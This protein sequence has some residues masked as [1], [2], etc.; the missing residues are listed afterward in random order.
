LKEYTEKDLIKYLGEN[1]AARFSSIIE[2]GTNGEA[3]S[4]LEFDDFEYAG[5]CDVSDQIRLYVLIS[6]L[7][8]TEYGIHHVMQFLESEPLLKKYA[9]RFRNLEISGDVLLKLK[10]PFLQKIGVESILDAVKIS[11][12][13][14]KWITNGERYNHEESKQDLISAIE[15][16]TDLKWKEE[17]MQARA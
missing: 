16:S 6:R 1:N 8:P 5:V 11:V 2:E 12:L 17:Y 9:E 4:E 10:A 13:F 15:A 14:R 7:K 3:L